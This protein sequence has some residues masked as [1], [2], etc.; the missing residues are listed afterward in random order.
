MSLW[1]ITIINKKTKCSI[2]CCHYAYYN[3]TSAGDRNLYLRYCVWGPHNLLSNGYQ[4]LFPWV[5]KRSWREADHSPPSSSEVKNAWSC[6]STPHYVFM[7][8]YLVKH[9]DITCTF[10]NEIFTWC[11]SFFRAVTGGFR[12]RQRG[13]CNHCFMKDANTCWT[14]WS[15][16][17]G[18][19]FSQIQRIELNTW[20]NK[21]IMEQRNTQM[22]WK[23]S[24]AFLHSTPL[25]LSLVYSVVPNCIL[26]YTLSNGHS[27][28]TAHLTLLFLTNTGHRLFCIHVHTVPGC[29]FSA[30]GHSVGWKHV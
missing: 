15:Y 8:W 23:V 27:Y 12:G 6:T 1:N 30:H 25:S 7:A 28:M 2:F 9:R 19:L 29:E 20:R 18:L 26:T 10:M 16:I 17:Y 24:A 4:G 5:I 21:E 11:H 22:V 3:L 14:K 13:E